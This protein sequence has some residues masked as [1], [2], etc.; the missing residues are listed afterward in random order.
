[1]NP[2]TIIL[3]L[4]RWL[5]DRKEYGCMGYDKHGLYRRHYRTGRVDAKNQFGWHPVSQALWYRFRP[6][7]EPYRAMV[8]PDGKPIHYSNKRRDEIG[9]IG[10]GLWIESQRRLVLEKKL[11]D[12]YQKEIKK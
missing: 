12:R 7:L 9:E 5:F 8:M 6:T 10:F 1:M 3:T 2:L 4:F 11:R